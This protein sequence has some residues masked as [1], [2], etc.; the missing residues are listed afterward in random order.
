MRPSLR[1]VEIKNLSERHTPA[2]GLEIWRSCTPVYTVTTAVAL[3]A[4]T[5]LLNLLLVG[6]LSYFFDLSFVVI[7]LLA[8]LMVRPG[9]AWNMALLP[10]ALLVGIVLLLA[11]LGSATVASPEDS[12]MQAI[13]TGVIGHSAALVAGWALFAAALW[14]NETGG[15]TVTEWDDFADERREN[16]SL[17][18]DAP[19]S[20]ADIT[21][22]SGLGNDEA[23]LSPELH[24]PSELKGLASGQPSNLDGSPAPTRSTSG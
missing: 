14:F 22:Q 15:D 19:L 23:L 8:G 3:L 18:E 24:G 12:V 9:E 11:P 1:P 21:Q 5:V 2:R 20:P 13:I 16:A 4:L 7:C 10:P 6:S 17:A